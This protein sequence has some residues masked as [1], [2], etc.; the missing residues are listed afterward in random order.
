MSRRIFQI[1]SINS[2]KRS[3]VYIS[4]RNRF[5]LFHLNNHHFFLVQLNWI[6]LV[7]CLVGI[8]VQ[9]FVGTILF[10]SLYY[11]AQ[12]VHLRCEHLL[13]LSWFNLTENYF[14]NEWWCLLICACVW[15]LDF[16]SWL[17]CMTDM[18]LEITLSF[19]HMLWIFL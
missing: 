19:L 18:E 10:L 8:L 2:V 16:T 11:L 4:F 6:H 5:L 14:G 9:I 13:I 1:W 17:N 3:I 12:P 7:F 15:W